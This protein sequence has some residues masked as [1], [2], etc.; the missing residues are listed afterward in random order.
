MVKSTYFTVMEEMEIA[1]GKKAMEIQELLSN[2]RSNSAVGIRIV[3]NFKN[4]YKIS[5]ECVEYILD[6]L[7]A[8]KHLTLEELE[9]NIF[10]TCCHKF[11][12]QGPEID[13]SKVSDKIGGAK[14][15]E[16]FIISLAERMKLSSIDKAIEIVHKLCN[17]I[18]LTPGEED[19]WHTNYAAW[20]TWSE[21]D[22]I[23]PFDFAKSPKELLKLLSSLGL[24]HRQEGLTHLLFTYSKTAVSEL[25]YP[26][27]ADAN[28]YSY[29]KCAD[30]T[31]YCGKTQPWNPEDVEQKGLNPSEIKPRPE[32][33]HPR[34]KLKE[35]D[36]P[37][38]VIKAS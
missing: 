17:D 30:S 35:I 3:D 37:V 14:A 25:R 18:E 15:K 5:K 6:E 28:L 24:T 12:L 11:T 29:F 26:T 2:W 32:A 10:S 4:D 22:P 21:I 8:N 27:I 19:V 7:H 13:L 16:E 20:V 33:V 31:D 23:N 36:K 9:V 1:D 34:I 38:K